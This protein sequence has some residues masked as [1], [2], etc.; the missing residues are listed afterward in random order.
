M[1]YGY[2]I[3]VLLAPTA[4]IGGTR[5][6][7]KAEVSTASSEYGWVI[8]ALPHG[9]AFDHATQFDIL[10]EGFES[11]TAA[12]AHGERFLDALR[13]ALTQTSTAVDFGDHRGSGGLTPESL[14]RAAQASGAQVLNGRLGLQVYRAE[15]QTVFMDMGNPRVGADFPVDKLIDLVDTVFAD[16][17]PLSRRESLALELFHAALFET[18]PRARLLL[19]VAAVESLLEPEVRGNQAKLFVDDLIIRTQASGMEKHEVDSIVGALRWL[20]KESISR[21]G[22]SLGSRLLA[23]R[24]YAD[25]PPDRFFAK[26]YSVRS[27]L[28]HSGKTTL[29]PDEFL[30]FVGHTQRFVREL[31]LA[32]VASMPRT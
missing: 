23:G 21:T 29:F 10:R 3:W 27:A 4:H 19:L 28:V 31:I 15:P 7:G 25:L 12:Q 30:G 22:R 1:S 16:A 2:R 13:L 18:R 17:P 9:T 11:E 14:D 8:R 5:G 32:H 6:H 24:E 20:R 26:V